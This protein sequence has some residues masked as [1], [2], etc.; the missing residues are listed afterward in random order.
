MSVCTRTG[1]RC[2]TNL[3]Q[4][5]YQSMVTSLGGGSTWGGRNWGKLVLTDELDFERLAGLG[6]GNIPGCG[7]STHA[8]ELDML[9]VSWPFRRI[10]CHPPV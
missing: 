6:V 2:S 7:L 1:V 10:F 4:G 3:P 8:W 9:G 5:T